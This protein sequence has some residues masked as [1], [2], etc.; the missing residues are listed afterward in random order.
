MAALVLALL[1]MVGALAFVAPVAIASE[2]ETPV[3]RHYVTAPN[4]PENQPGATFEEQRASVM[5]KSEG[6]FSCHVRTDEPSMH[7]SPA[8]QLGCVDCHGGDANVRG[9]PA[10]GYTHPDN[11]AALTRAHVLPRYPRSWNWPSS[12]NPQRSYTLLNR[13]APEFIRFVNPADYRIAREACGSCHLAII[14]N[15]ERS[16]MATGAMLW[17]GA[18][19]NNG[20]VP[21]KSYLMGESYTREGDP[22]C[23]TS[24]SSIL[25]R[26]EWARACADITL[27]ADA[28]LTP[29]EQAR[30][31]LARLYPLPSWTVIPPGDVFRVFER[32]GRSI[33]PVFPEIGLPNSTGQIQRLDEPG[34]PDLRQSNRGSGHRASRRHPRPQHPQ[35]AAQRPVHVVHGDQ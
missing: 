27:P 3:E 6:C 8:V 20:I 4:A 33:N 30:G 5:A 35:N 23:I 16:M 19:Y 25:P 15:A 32:G 12:A 28:I 7:A 14:E 26:E 11:I 10:L 9:D 29:E 24:P 13:E 18:A 34:R 1:A 31:A 21:F 22:A 2:G 17:G